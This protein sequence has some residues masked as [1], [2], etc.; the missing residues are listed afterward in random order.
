MAIRYGHAGQP[1]KHE[2]K[3]E[4]WHSFE[5][6]DWR[7]NVSIRQTGAAKRSASMR[8]RIPE[9]GMSDEMSFTPALRFNID[10]KR[11]PAMP[12]ANHDADR[13]AQRADDQEPQRR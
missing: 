2:N 4:N 7:L 3:K 1:R 5:L 12:S 6:N 11:S 9:T 8:S 13:R 10:S